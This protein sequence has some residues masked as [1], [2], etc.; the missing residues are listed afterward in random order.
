M[1][2]ATI[3]FQ[4]SGQRGTISKNKSVLEAA[5]EVGENIESLCGGKGSCGKCRVLIAEG[6]YPKYGVVSSRKHL[7]GWEKTESRYIN[8]KDKKKGYRLAC[9]AAIKGDVLVFVPEE[10]R[11]SKQIVSKRPGLLT[12]DYDPVVKK[13][14]LFVDPPSAGD[15]RGDLERLIGALN[16]QY[17]LKDLGCDIDTLYACDIDVLRSIPMTIREQNWHVTVSVWM[18]REIIRI[19]PGKVLDSFGIAVDIGT[20]TVVASL[21]H[22]NAMQIL[23]TQ[24]IMNPQVKY[25]EDVI[26]RINYHVSNKEGLDEMSADIIEALNG[27][28]EALLR[29][30]WP[31][32]TDWPETVKEFDDIEVQKQRAKTEGKFLCLIPEDIEDV[33]IVGNT[34][35]HHILLKFDPRH[36]ARAP[37]APVVQKSL[38]IKARNLKLD[39]C[40]SAYVH[41][42]PNEAGFVGADNVAVLTAEA[43]Y[44]SDQIQLI[45]D[46]GTNGELVLGNRKRL[47][48][49]SCATGPAFEGAEITFGMRAAPGAVEHIAIDSE[50]HEVVYKVVGHDAWSNY[51]KPGELQVR[52]ICGSGIMDLLAE[53][54]RGGIITKSGAFRRD[55]STRRF[56]NNSETGQREF[57]IAWAAEAAIGRDITITQKDIR[58]I[59]LAKAAIY[60][61]CKLLMQEWGTDR[62]DV[63]KIAGGFG[64]HIDPV[65]ALIMGMIPDCDPDQIIAIGNA[66]GAGALVTLVNREKRSESDWVARTVEYVDLALLKGFKDEFVE[67]LHIPHKKDPFPHL[68]PMVPPEILFQK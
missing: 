35:M 38:N 65:K 48:S 34:V 4:P 30:T 64:L 16:V 23:D 49:T 42:L 3:I 27:M 33:T 14:D 51:V 25:G 13:Y 21:V 47:L 63:V 62:V 32:N 20:T 8:K 5:R 40:P 53:L 39:M 37:F 28:T 12:V 2:T 46:I 22:L 52:G 68:E 18:D 26:S 17:G 10:S 66:A 61:G 24:Y 44:E 54:Y 55:L 41:I 7:S 50:T 58:Q 43:P 59:Q 11:A 1:K 56:R 15:S 57:V 9:C 60:V 19:V 36:V 6:R 29:S 45:I 31:D 67:A